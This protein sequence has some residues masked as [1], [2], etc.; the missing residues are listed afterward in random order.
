M[1]EEMLLKKLVDNIEKV[2]VGKREVIELAV[3]GLIS[4]GHIL[5]EDIPGVG[6]TMLA[7]SLAKSIKADFKRIQFTAFFPD[8]VYVVLYVFNFNSKM[9]Y[10]AL[11]GLV[12]S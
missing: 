7:R 3:I 2:I 6:K 5:I 4:D 8:V 1:R 11:A 12:C 9:V 10:T